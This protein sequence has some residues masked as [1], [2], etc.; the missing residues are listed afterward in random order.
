MTET[1]TARARRPTVRRLE[2]PHGT[3]APVCEQSIPHCA[4]MALPNVPTGHAT[5]ELPTAVFSPSRGRTRQLESTTRGQK[6]TR[7]WSRSRRTQQR[8]NKRSR[9]LSEH[10]LAREDYIANLRCD[11]DTEYNIRSTTQ[12]VF[13]FV[14]D[15]DESLWQ[16]T[17]NIFGQMSPHH[18]CSRPANMSFHNLCESNK[19]PPGTANLLGLGLKYCLEAPKPQVQHSDLQRSLARF[20]RSVRIQHAILSQDTTAEDEEPVKYI[21][22]LCVPSKW[23]P[24]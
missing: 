3:T 19:L 4:T 6:R 10:Y 12:R 11:R 17:A 24:Q 21:P 2:T 8:A 18:F 14:P 1:P 9:T 23:Q 5:A 22:G 15:T 16:N 20:E 13:G 7:P